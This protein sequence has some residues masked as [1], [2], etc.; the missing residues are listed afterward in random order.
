MITRR[1][2]LSVVLA[3][4]AWMLGIM[5][6]PAAGVHAHEAEKC[7]TLPSLER[8]ISAQGKAMLALLNEMEPR[9][10]TGQGSLEAIR[11]QCA[12]L[13]GGRDWCREL[14]PKALAQD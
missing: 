8:E 7:P 11:Q 12:E 13:S 10:G 6:I 14:G 3:V 2:R 9:L 4:A 5:L 1:R